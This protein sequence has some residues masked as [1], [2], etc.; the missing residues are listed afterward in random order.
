MKRNSRIDVRWMGALALAATL[1][2]GPMV[3]SALAYDA[4][5]PVK[6]D[7][8]VTYSRDSSWLSSDITTVETLGRFG[9]GGSDGG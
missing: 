4:T 2:F 8:K 1:V 5:Y 6:S 7:K 9:G 3:S